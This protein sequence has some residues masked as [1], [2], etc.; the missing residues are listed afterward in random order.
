MKTQIKIVKVSELLD[1]EENPTLCLNP[2]RALGICHKCGKYLNFF[3]HSKTHKLKCNP[4]INP[5]IKSL[6]EQRRKE[7][8]EHRIEIARIAEYIKQLE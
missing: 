4:Q 8:R 1:K 5:K 2:L 3:S 7:I 6:M